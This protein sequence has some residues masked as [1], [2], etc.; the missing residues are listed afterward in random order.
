MEEG[1]QNDL[2]AERHARK[3]FRRYMQRDELAAE[4]TPAEG[5]GQL[6]SQGSAA[7]QLGELIDMKVENDLSS[8]DGRTTESKFGEETQFEKG[9]RLSRQLDPTSVPWKYQ[10]MKRTASLGRDFST[11]VDDYN[12]FKE[13]RQAVEAF[14]ADLLAKRELAKEHSTTH[15]HSRPDPG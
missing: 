7:M 3:Q 14:K 8:S 15:T 12:T 11:A 1:D 2:R 9:D 4:P 13:N 5:H 10:D 6:S